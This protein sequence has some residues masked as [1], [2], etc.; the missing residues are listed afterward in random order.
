MKIKMLAFLLIILAKLPTTLIVSGW[1]RHSS[2]E[3]QLVSG[4]AGERPSW[5][6]AQLIS[7]ITGEWHTCLVVP[8][9]IHK[10][11]Q[12]HNADG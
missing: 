10:T 7:F 4:T 3:T 6:V 12:L 1:L 11:G 9:M 8:L 2:A 5:L